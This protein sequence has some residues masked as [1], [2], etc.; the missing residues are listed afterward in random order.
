MFNFIPTRLEANRD[1]RFNASDAFID[2]IKEGMMNQVSLTA[3]YSKF[4]SACAAS[5]CTYA[6]KGRQKL[7]IIITNL[8]SIC[9]GLSVALRLITPFLFYIVY[10]CLKFFQ[11][12]CKVCICTFLL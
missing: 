1:T 6:L 4:F 11:G 9:S 5:N 8:I 10:G 7:V 2:I 3:P 12:T